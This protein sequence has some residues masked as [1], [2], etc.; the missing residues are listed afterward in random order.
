MDR[1]KHERYDF[2]APLSFYWGGPGGVRHR[3]QGLLRNMSGGGVFV[4]TDDSPPEKARIQFNMSFRSLFPGSR[5]VIRA[6]AQVVRVDS[7]APLQGNVGF[8][9]AMKTFTL[10]NDRKKLLERGI[11]DEE[12]KSDKLKNKTLIK[13]GRSTLLWG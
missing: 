1:R 10:R 13:A 12:L 7:A 6:C 8:A 3:Y 5:L 9:A 11:V 4:L 2:E